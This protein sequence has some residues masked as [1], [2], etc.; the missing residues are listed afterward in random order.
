MLPAGAYTVESLIGHGG[1]GAVYRGTQLRLKRPVA[2]KIMRQDVEADADFSARFL[3]EAHTLARLSHPGI[4][5]VIDCGKDG[6]DLS[7]IIMEFVDGTDLAELMRSGPLTEER[8]LELLP[9]MCDALQFAHD[10]GII[11][12]DIKPSNILIGRNGRVKLVDFGLARP[13]EP[14]STLQSGSHVSSGTPFYAAPEQ[15][16]PS[17]AL[18]HRAD[19]FALGV[20]LYQMLTGQLP[21]GAWQLPSQIAAVSRKWDA[22]VERAMQQRAEDRHASASLLRADALAISTA[23]AS[24]SEACASSRRS[25]RLPLMAC[26]AFVALVIAGWFTQ[27]LWKTGAAAGGV[28]TTQPPPSIPLPDPIRIWDAADKIPKQPGVAWEDDALRLDNTSVSQSFPAAHE[29][30]VRASIRFNPDTAGVN[31]S[32]RTALGD[33][34]LYLLSVDFAQSAL[35]LQVIE[36]LH[37]QQRFLKKW[38]LPRQY[39]PGEWLPVELRADGGEI[40]V[41]LEGRLMGSVRDDT[42]TAFTVYTLWSKPYAHFRDIGYVPLGPEQQAPDSATPTPV[43][44]KEPPP[45]Q[46]VPAPA[47]WVDVTSAVQT[48]VVSAGAGTVRDGRLQF[49]Q[50]HY[51]TLPDGLIHEDVAVRMKLRGS[52]GIALRAI[53][54]YRSYQSGVDQYGASLW[55]WDGGLNK[56][57]LF[58]QKL[59]LT[60]DFDPAQ[61]YELLM[62]VRGDLIQAWVNGRLIASHRDSDLKQGRILLSF[63][64]ADVGSPLM[65]NL[66]KVEYA[67][68]KQQP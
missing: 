53:P 33:T 67:V 28:A 32:L 17:A 18:D 44:L 15:L 3:R 43:F 50:K 14:G 24:A 27:D 23:S 68:L 47:A 6:A 22:I 49:T 19:I 34:G 65:P 21:R 46:P 5:N 48:A 59:P 40:S 37:T 8:V 52:G 13:V 4:V 62:A 60:P 58:D 36:K 9:Q 31:I 20:L 29:I 1:M 45:Q 16:T 7:Y 57:V 2:I 51:L 26:A 35:V 42:H 63:T 54:G 66:Q 39:R 11:H 56:R 64:A 10:N 55:C 61:D 30:A 38:D 25:L 41:S 12:R